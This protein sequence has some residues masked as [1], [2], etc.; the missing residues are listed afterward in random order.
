MI[1]SLTDVVDGLPDIFHQLASKDSGLNQI[2]G[3]DL[4]GLLQSWLVSGQLQAPAEVLP[5]IISLPLTVLLQ[6][7]QFLRHLND[8][9]QG[10]SYESLLQRLQQHGVQG[11]CAGLLTAAAIAFSGNDQELAATAGVSL[12]LAMCIGAYVDRNS[13]YADTPDPACAYSVRWRE[14]STRKEVEKVLKEYPRV[15]TIHRLA[16]ASL[17]HVANFLM[18]GLHLM[19]DRQHVCDGHVASRGWPDVSQVND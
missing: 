17:C 11:F 7:A 13:A 1:E 19:C 8:I 2:P 15:S 4:L 5:N 12:R 3:T 9:G 18:K 10:S 16:M 6:T 14:G